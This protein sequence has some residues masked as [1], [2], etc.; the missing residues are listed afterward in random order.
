MFSSIVPTSVIYWLMT[1]KQ[2]CKPDL[3]WGQYFCLQLD[4][5]MLLPGRQLCASSL[6]S[7][8]PFLPLCPEMLLELPSIPCPKVQILEWSS[9]LP[10]LPIFNMSA[11]PI[12]CS[13]NV[14]PIWPVFFN[15]T[16]NALVQKLSITHL[17]YCHSS[18]SILSLTSLSTL[19]PSTI[20]LPSDLPESIF[21][22]SCLYPAL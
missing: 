19:K 6:K 1:C 21:N 9:T 8:P 17:R 15:S 20:V 10:S 14:F 7:I 2:I 11:S 18:P 16:A 3:F 13:Q 5:S 12:R 4:M 22:W